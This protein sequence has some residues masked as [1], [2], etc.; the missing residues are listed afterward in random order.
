MLPFRFLAPVSYILNFIR[1]KFSCEKQK[2]ASERANE[3]AGRMYIK[4]SRMSSACLQIFAQVLCCA[5]VHN[6][7]V[8]ILDRTDELVRPLNLLSVSICYATSLPVLLCLCTRADRCCFRKTA[9]YSRL[10][11]DANAQPPIITWAAVMVVAATPI[12]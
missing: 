11:S 1:H 5:V 2:Q 7:C 6:V 3:R 8:Q 10:P 9:G 4:I 12:S